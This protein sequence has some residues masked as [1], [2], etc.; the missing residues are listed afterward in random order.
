MDKK[1]LIQASQ[2]EGTQM[3]K[4]HK[5]KLGLISHEDTMETT[6]RCHSTP[7]GRELK[8]HSTKVGRTWECSA[9]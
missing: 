4:R 1:M 5:E 2:K 9:P 8:D 3:A 6:M 7:T